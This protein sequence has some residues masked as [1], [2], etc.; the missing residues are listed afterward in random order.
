MSVDRQYGCVVFHCDD[1]DCDE[2][3]ETKSRDM[4]SAQVEKREAGWVSRKIDETWK[5][6]C[7][8]CK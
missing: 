6:L 4:G 1:K 2:A 7:P 3:L 5:D 8:A